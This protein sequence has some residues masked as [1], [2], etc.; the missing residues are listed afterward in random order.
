MR[1]AQLTDSERGLVNIIVGAVGGQLVSLLAAPLLAR[2]YSPADF[3]VFTVVSTLAAT[4]GTVAA[5][6]FELAIPL[7]EREADAH[8]L[9]I[10]GL[11]A[12]TVTAVVGTLVVL[13]FGTSLVE[14]FHQPGLM[15]WLW[16][17]PLT[18]AAMAAVMVLTQLAI[19]HGRYSGIGRRN[20]GQSIVMNIAQVVGGAAGSGPGGIVSGYGAG[21]V[22]AALSLVP[23]SRFRSAEAR[24]GRRWPNLRETALRYWRFPLLLTPSGL[25]NILGTQLPVLLIAYR[26]G[27]EVAGW[28]GLTQ[29]V[30]ALP[31]ALVGTAV[32]QVYLAELSRATRT[33]IARTRSLF[34]QATM[35]LTLLG[36]AG[37][38]AIFAAGPYAFT[39]VFGA[40]WTNSGLYAR[41]LAL[42]VTSQF[43][44]APLSQTLIVLER[45]NL[46]FAWDVGRTVL[47]TVAVDV[48]AVSG[49]TPVMAMWVFGIC[50][51][52]AYAASWILSSR[53]VTAAWSRREAGTRMH[54]SEPMPVGTVSERSEPRHR[55]PEGTVGVPSSPNGESE[56]ED[57]AS[58]AGA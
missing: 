39:L 46:Q 22:A 20:L 33:D 26:Y 31:M 58:I 19:R 29:R 42:G 52:I 25:F 35:K 4:V 48:A 9:V 14:R 12:A 45:Q 41:A 57:L 28:M 38:I 50:S 13:V 7:P 6:R 15:P 23:G 27:S 11:A 3:G 18:A 49:A 32:A 34:Q 47:V 53:S 51:T 5:F 37:G 24:A 21:Q 55:I 43:V 54:G 56:D 44:A 10:L 2:L 30:L 8:S 1:L 40:G 16:F 36:V 17:V